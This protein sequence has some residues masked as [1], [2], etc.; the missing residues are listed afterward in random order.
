MWS[1]CR[2]VLVSYKRKQPA[3]SHNN[4][5]RLIKYHVRLTLV[6]WPY[7]FC[8][9]YNPIP[10]YMKS[11]VEM[12]DEQ[13]IQLYVNNNPHA[14]ATLTE[15]YKDRIY[16]TI[17]GMVQD[18]DAAEEIFAKVFSVIINSL[19]AGKSYSDNGFMQW[20]FS[21]SHQLC[22]EHTRKN[23]TSCAQS[24]KHNTTGSSVVNATAMYESG[25]Y[26]SHAQIKT[27]I[28]QLPG[29][30]RE[31]MALNHYGG[32]SFKEIAGILKCSVTMALDIMQVGLNNLRKQ[33]VEK[34]ILVQ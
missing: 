11:N 2:H 24:N 20:A 21:I 34:Q 12:T 13:L 29:Q 31:V 32:L 17:F 15:L 28:A 26:N 25:Y 3:F 23:T 27:M 4:I 9:T 30:Q 6:G 1:R 22:I 18:K 19:I 14:S 5:L 10:I 16:A 33:M 8:A 7:Y